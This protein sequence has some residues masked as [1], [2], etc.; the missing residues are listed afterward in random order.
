MVILTG[1]AVTGLAFTIKL[2][3]LGKPSFEALVGVIGAL[4]C[5]FLL[6]FSEVIILCFMCRMEITKRKSGKYEI[7][8]NIESTEESE[9]TES[10]EESEETEESETS[11]D[12]IIQD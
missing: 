11:N 5:V 2:D 4:V 10:T 9:E 12:I 1:L 8:R 6:I 7:L 3:Y